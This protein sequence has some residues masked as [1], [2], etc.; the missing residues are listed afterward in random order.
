MLK[1]C[2]LTGLI[3]LL[4]CNQ[5]T[6]PETDYSFT[7]I[8]R[9]SYFVQIKGKVNRIIESR[10]E[11]FNE[12]EQPLMINPYIKFYASEEERDNDEYFYSKQG[13][14]GSELGT[15]ESSLNGIPIYSYGLLDTAKVLKVGEQLNHLITTDTLH[16]KGLL[17]WRFKFVEQKGDVPDLLEQIIEGEIKNEFNSYY[18]SSIHNTR[19]MRKRYR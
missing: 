11:I 7:F 15:I 12:G 16:Q 17:Y 2:L 4:G 19:T 9:T 13:Y 8:I 5:L 3:T 18:T 14:L 1:K 6:A 10:G